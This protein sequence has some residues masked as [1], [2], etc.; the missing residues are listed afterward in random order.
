M[1]LAKIMNCCLYQ[2]RLR[3]FYGLCP[4]KKTRKEEPNYL[5]RTESQLDQE[6][7]S[8]FGINYTL[9]INALHPYFCGIVE[10]FEADYELDR[11]SGPCYRSH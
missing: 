7:Q 8:S 6:V 2:L 1:T 9:A 10:V 4:V 5:K 11:S 3:S